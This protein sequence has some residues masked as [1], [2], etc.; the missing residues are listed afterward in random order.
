[1]SLSI[2]CGEAAAHPKNP[3]EKKPRQHCRGFLN[4]QTGEIVPKAPITI[5]ST[6]NPNRK[7]A[8][9][10]ITASDY[11]NNGSDGS[12]GT[13]AANHAFTKRIVGKRL[14]A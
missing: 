6:R 11:L 12:S 1:M 3:P 14:F 4:T 8:I 10:P 7:I 9:L 13:S 2:P 5:A